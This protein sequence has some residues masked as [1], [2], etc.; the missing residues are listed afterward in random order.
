[1]PTRLIKSS[2]FILQAYFLNGQLWSLNGTP[3]QNG[4]AALAFFR[5]WFV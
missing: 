1:M 4:T 5:F 2:A 3:T